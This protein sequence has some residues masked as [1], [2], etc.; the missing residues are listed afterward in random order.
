MGGPITVQ[1]GG[2]TISPSNLVKIS[3][4]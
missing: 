1:I 3:S 4:K 2:N